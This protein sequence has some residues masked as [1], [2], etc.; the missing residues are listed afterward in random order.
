MR[1]KLSKNLH[2]QTIKNYRKL[3]LNS[4]IVW[5]QNYFLHKPKGVKGDQPRARPLIVLLD[6]I[7]LRDIL[8]TIASWPFGQVFNTL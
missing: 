8:D 2:Q 5:P 1:K 6:N 3:L 4:S 7:Q